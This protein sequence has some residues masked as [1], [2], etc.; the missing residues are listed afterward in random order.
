MTDLFVYGTL[1]AQGLMSAVSASP[2]GQPNAAVL[3]D[4]QVFPV[5][6]DV[7]PFIAP[8]VGGQARGLIWPELSD[9]A[10]RRLTAYETAFGYRLQDV[11]VIVDGQARR[12]KAYLPA[13]DQPP[14]DGDWSLAAW[15]ARHLAPAIFAA[16]E[17][18]ARD[19]LPDAAT[20]RQMWPMIETRAWARHRARSAPAT[21]RHRAAADDAAVTPATPAAGAFFRFQGFDVSHARF[22]GTRSPVL[23]RE[24]F[25]GVDAALLLPYD[26]VR[27]R[28]VLVEQVRVG[29]MVRGDANPWTLEPVAGIVDARE[30]P[31]DAARREAVEES[32][33]RIQTLVPAG[34]YYPSPGATTDYFYAYV[35]LCDIAAEAPYTGGL[36]AE[37]ED[38][39]LHPTDFAAAMALAD[40]GE[41]TT[42]PLL[43]L[44]F[45]LAR[46]RDRLR[47]MG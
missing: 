12:A 17:L 36:D 29:P 24:V 11:S 42:G 3:P 10:M 4:H 34:S 43:H 30:S 46:H 41:I 23:R 47:A 27:D 18:L 25:V 1:M 7:V 28:V 32:G 38:I 19:P 13:T 22:D 5:A 45:W 39:R 33:L 44:L 8:V 15:E 37:A 40:S 20:L 31:P 6:G 26:P 21:I 16:E 2:L 35:G 14:G 9:V